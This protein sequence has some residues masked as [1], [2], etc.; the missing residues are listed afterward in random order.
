MK[1]HHYIIIKEIEGFTLYHTGIKFSTDQ[2]EA[3]KYYNYPTIT[4]GAESLKIVEVN[5]PKEDEKTWLYV[6]KILFI[7]I[8]FGSSI[9]GLILLIFWLWN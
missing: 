3:E 5:E 1:I 8:I 7:S 4:E 6:V 2:R 9:I